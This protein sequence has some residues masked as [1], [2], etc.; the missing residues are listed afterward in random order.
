MQV[1][2]PRVPALTWSFDAWL[3]G[4]PGS[5]SMIGLFYE[6]IYLSSHIR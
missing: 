3:Q 2:T 6:V 5:P 1:F 4:G